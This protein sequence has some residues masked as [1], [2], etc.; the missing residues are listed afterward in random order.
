MCLRFCVFFFHFPVV[1]FVRRATHREASLQFDT[2]KNDRKR[3]AALA[4][5]N[6]LNKQQ[7][8]QA[9]LELL[10]HREPFTGHKK[11]IAHKTRKI[12]KRKQ[13]RKTKKI[14]TKQ[15]Q[16]TP[17]NTNEKILC[18]KR[19]MRWYVLSPNTTHKQTK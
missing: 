10:Y 3:A 5:C 6:Q 14:K 15:S 7:V 9:G 1:R 4:F 12:K 2:L 8:A 11:K 17:K 18:W 19:A 16:G 13:R